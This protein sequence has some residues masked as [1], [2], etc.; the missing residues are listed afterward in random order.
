MKNHLLFQ[1]LGYYYQY[2]TQVVLCVFILKFKNIILNIT[3][4]GFKKI[5]KLA[6]RCWLLVTDT[7]LYFRWGVHMVCYPTIIIIKVQNLFV[8]KINSRISIQLKQSLTQNI[9]WFYPNPWLMWPSLI[10][11]PHVFQLVLTSGLLYGVEQSFVS[12]SWWIHYQTLINL[13]CN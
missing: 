3:N 9:F 1:P 5:K 8:Q 4:L 2:I 6:K 11:S 10:I 7:I 12:M 13:V